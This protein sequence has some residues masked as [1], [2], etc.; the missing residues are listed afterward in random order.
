MVRGML[1]LFRTLSELGSCDRADSQKM[2]QEPSTPGKHTGMGCHSLLQGIFLTQGSNS[3][4]L[5]CRQILQHLSHQG[6]PPKSQVQDIKGYPRKNDTLQEHLDLICLG[7][8]HSGRQAQRTPFLRGKYT[9]ALPDCGQ[10]GGGQKLCHHE[11]VDGD[12]DC[13]ESKNLGEL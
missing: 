8:F 3:S 6:S 1:G 11:A 13:W 9:S 10:P 4:L 12:Q 7:T 2:Q 5:R